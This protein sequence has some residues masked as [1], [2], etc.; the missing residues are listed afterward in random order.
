MRYE[1]QSAAPCLVVKAEALT[2]DGELLVLGSSLDLCALCTYR[3][4]NYH[5]RRQPMPQLLLEAYNTKLHQK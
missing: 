4:D 5:Q 2:A 3:E 1:E